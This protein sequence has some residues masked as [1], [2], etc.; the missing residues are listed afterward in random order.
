MASYNLTDLNLGK[1]KDLSLKI[2]F[3]C[4]LINTSNGVFLGYVTQKKTIRY[5][6]YAQLSHH[7]KNTNF[8]EFYSPDDALIVQNI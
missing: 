4:F 3:N 6:Y 5:T 7:Q 2:I 1:I 8:Y